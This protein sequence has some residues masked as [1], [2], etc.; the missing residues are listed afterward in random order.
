MENL[1][2]VEKHRKRIGLLLAFFLTLSAYL[3]I[4]VYTITSAYYEDK[5]ENES[6]IF[7]SS[8]VE[9]LIKIYWRFDNIEND[10]L[11]K[12]ILRV[13]AY[14]NVYVEWEIIVENI[15]IPQDIFYSTKNDEITRYEKFKIYKNNIVNDDWQVYTYITEIV[16]ESILSKVGRIIIILF[17][18]SPL[19]Y[20]IL[21][22]LMCRFMTQ[23]YK[24]LKEIIVNL[25]SF[26]SN[27]NHEFKTS[28]TEIISSLELARVTKEY[29]EA[30]E[31][32]I[33]SAR[34]LDSMLDTLWMLI[35][36]VNSDYRKERVNL[37]KILE[38]SMDDLDTFITSKHIKITRKYNPEK[39]LYKY[40]DKSPLI[41]T[42]QNIM[43]NAIKYSEIGWSIEIWIY[44]DH[45]SVKDYWIWI[46][47]ENLDKIFD[48]Y[49]RESY[50]KSWSG[51]WLSIIKRITEIY[52]WDIKV[53]S[54][55]WKYTKVTIYY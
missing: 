21:A 52:K 9:S 14:T 30:N 39:V 42:F 3:L 25:E 6:L 10:E 16:S 29:K 55:K 22:F 11:K 2:L 17:I 43:K 41:L 13:M 51:I 26:A 1:V 23:M 8:R 32:S 40:I 44:R 48:R 20:S 37:Y 31:Y 34:R 49:F 33:S 5:S 53:Q 35:H 50:S 38:S 7:N 24:P 46:A 28:L 36:F 45:F 18:L 27:I 4:L 15:D 54:K 47:E 12:V 19:V